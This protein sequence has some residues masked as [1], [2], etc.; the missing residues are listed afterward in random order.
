MMDLQKA[1]TNFL[2]AGMHFEICG[3]VFACA[4]ESSEHTVVR[5]LA[6]TRSGLRREFDAV[7][8]KGITRS[9]IEPVA[10]RLRSLLFI[11]KQKRTVSIYW[12]R[13][14]PKEALGTTVN[15]NY[16]ASGFCHCRISIG[17]PL[18]E[19]PRSL[20]RGRSLRSTILQEK[21]WASLVLTVPCVG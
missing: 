5:E 4:F 16:E 2:E 19:R 21:R 13:G 6:R 18:E 15:P 17:A 14:R 1:S 20:S 11:K 10:F 3:T 12:V 7:A 9:S 8:H